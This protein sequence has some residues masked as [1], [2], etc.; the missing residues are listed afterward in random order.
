MRRVALVALLSVLVLSSIP[1][2]SSGDGDPPPGAAPAVVTLAA[3]SI[4][5]TGATLN[6]SVSPNGLETTAWFEWGTDATLAV[7]STTPARALGAGLVPAPV[8]E[9]LTGLAAGTTYCYRIAAASSTGPASGS[10]EC[11]T[12]TSSSVFGV[13]STSPVD[14]ATGVP[15]GSDFT[16]TFSQDVEPASL[17]G[18]I[19][20]LG[21]GG[22]V[23]GVVSYNA[24][25]RTATFA[26]AAPLAP[27]T[28]YTV[29]VE[30]KV[31]SVYTVRLAAPY[32]VRFTSGAA[33]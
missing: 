19:T 8:G 3:T 30:A 33:R 24:T 26:P 1:S 13:V 7:R 28:D 14:G 29:T 23:P 11:F 20:V 12:T 17:V 6:G 15:L 18:A 4:G 5:L 22:D 25:T 31:K 27:L 21:P 16:V 2:C 9:A 10:I 32:V